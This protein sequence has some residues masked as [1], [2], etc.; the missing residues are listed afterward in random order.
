MGGNKGQGGTSYQSSQVQIPAE[1]LARYNSVNARAESVAN[2]PWQ[3]Y[4]GQFVA[5]VNQT[6]T[7]GINA[8]TGAAG[9]DTPYFNQ[10]TGV[11]NQAIPQTQQLYGTAQ[12]QVGAGLA[13]GQQ[14]T[15]Q[16]LGTAAGASG[17][18]S[19]Y[20]STASGQLNNAYGATQPINNAA[21]GLAAG[22]T[23]AVNAG[24]LDINRYMSPYNEAVVQST[25]GNLRQQQ[26]ME[27]ADLRDSQIL[28]G[29]FGGDRS[30][31]G[32]ANLKRQQDM[33][34]GQVASQL[35]N[36]NYGQA[37]STAAQ[38]QSVNLGADQA[39]RA[40][41]ASGAQNLAGIGNQ[42][43]GQ[44]A[45]AAQGNLGIGNQV[46]GQ[47]MGLASAQFQGGNQLYQQG[48]GAAGANA[49]IASGMAGTAAG[50]AG[51]LGQLGTQQQQNQLTQGQA[52]IGAG[53]VQQQT[54]Q[55]DATAQYNQFLQERGYPFQVAQ[56]LANIALGTGAQSGSTTNTVNTQAQPYFSDERLKE[57]VHV[58]GHTNDGQPIIRFNYKGDKSTQ[59]GLSAQETEKHHPDA[60]G[61]AGGYKT[62]DYDAATR[63]SIAKAGGGGLAAGND[64]FAQLLNAQRAMF[65][66]GAHDPRGIATGIGPHGIPI[67]PLKGQAPQTAKVS[68]PQGQQQTGAKRDIDSISSLYNTGKG[69]ASGYSEG[70]DALVGTAG[71]NGQPGTGG[72]LGTGGKWDPKEGWFG[73]Q[74]GNENTPTPTITATE[75]PAPTELV[76]PEAADAGLALGSGSWFAAGGAVGSPEIVVPTSGLGSG[77]LPFSEGDS[78]TIPTVGE[79]SLMRGAATGEDSSGGLS[80]GQMSDLNTPS[81]G[82]A[83]AR[84][85]RMR[86]AAGG[87]LGTMPYAAEGYIP[88]ELYK[89]IEPEKPDEADKVKMGAQGAGGGKD[90]TGKAIGSMVGGLAGSFFGPAGSMA[91]STMGGML[92]GLF[93]EGGRVGLAAGGGVMD[94]DEASR[95][96]L[97]KPDNVLPFVRPGG[98]AVK[99][100]VD[101]PSLPMPNPPSAPEGL[102]AGQPSPPEAFG[103]TIPD[104]P[105]APEIGAERAAVGPEP[106]GLAT[107]APAAPAA[108]PPGV[109]PSA[110]STL[111]TAK[112]MMPQPN[113][114]SGFDAAVDKTFRYEGGFNPRDSNGVPVNFGINQ[115][116]HPNVDVSKIT[117]DQAKEIYRNQYWNAIEGD[118]L[119]P[120]IQAIAFDTAVISGPA[121]AKEFLAASGGDPAKFMQLREAFEE[122]LIKQNPEKYGKYQ[123]AWANRRA[124]LAGKGPVT[125]LN[126]GR[127]P[128]AGQDSGLASGQ[129]AAPTT[130][131][132]Q[133]TPDFIDRAGNWIDRNQRPIM[134]GLAFIGNMLGSKSHQLTGAIGDGLAA[135]AP[136]YMATGFKETEL[137]QGQQR[138]DITGRAQ[139]ISVL[140][141]L[142]AM[143]SSNIANTGKP[144]PDIDAQIANVAKQITSLG[145]SSAAPGGT[146]GTGG[147]GGLA[148]GAAPAARPER[149]DLAPQGVPA[150]SPG[151]GS[152]TATPLPAPGGTPAPAEPTPGASPTPASNAKDPYAMP[153]PDFGNAGFRARMKPEMNP[154]TWLKRAADVA[155]YS[156]QEAAR[157][158]NHAQELE[159]RLRQTGETIDVNGQPLIVPGWREE[160]AAK[161]RMQTN[162]QY[163]EDQRK[164]AGSRELLKNQVEL[165]KDLTNKYESGA[166]NSVWADVDSKM[167]AVGLPGLKG[168]DAASYQQFM[169]EA[170]AVL[171]AQSQ[172]MPAGHGPTDALR[173]QIQTSFAAPTLE[174]DANRKILAN[175]TALI[176]WADKNYTDTMKQLESKPWLDTRRFYDDWKQQNNLQD[177]TKAADKE[178]TTA[179]MQVPKTAAELED[180]RL[181]NMTPQDIFRLRKGDPN[182]KLEDIVRDFGGKPRMRLRA[183]I[184][185][186]RLKLVP[187][188]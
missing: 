77:G 94:E 127:Q 67:A 65:P 135:A 139:L 157:M 75:L 164:I 119:D 114:G 70:K 123:Q 91:G 184:V 137:K 3:P 93:N 134:A 159:L 104:L 61:L 25:L 117:K 23:G 32:A 181:Y 177:F 41:L 19:G 62:V 110:A 84:G 30:G 112:S 96:A 78:G 59:I 131:A 187:E 22:A 35:Y 64:N 24:G 92:G 108:A 86:R 185:D 48:V 183:K 72:L 178:T 11:I 37:L 121:R 146:G 171:L 176:N 153:A 7:G 60:V 46:Y 133:D 88:E 167:K 150:P 172:S 13:S 116:F 141:Q 4:G 102:A 173:Q 169:K 1:V 80:A 120:A 124:D 26:G 15:Q 5:P 125:S 2:T 103:P 118:K 168:G 14:Y 71:K 163:A 20:N 56:F 136:M 38:Q 83:W 145:G 58:I 55:A 9:T 54:A 148:G 166:L 18:A 149:T 130:P 28:G 109:P 154:D 162:P 42:M 142:K 81:W 107:P 138:I 143:Q 147:T 155:A 165:L 10:A 151:A 170:A 31:V 33:A 50:T 158:R 132:A 17:D 152:V 90:G 188:Q 175:T 21:L 34:Y 129:S 79:G 27:Q 156:P 106:T 99:P 111:A 126:A 51:A 113:T 66:G 73:K 44:G 140:E 122:G 186:G 45:A 97:E 12:G 49:G 29:A 174:P 47:G 16:G 76:A 89:P 68:M 69:L 74:V 160:Q 95:I 43:F 36:A 39:N 52:Q 105:T 144:N 161:Q 179:G 8:I 100:S 101:T 182:V 6:Q 115:Q 85:G 63:D 180:G 40:A 87:G 128:T 82:G 98:P 53:T 57:N